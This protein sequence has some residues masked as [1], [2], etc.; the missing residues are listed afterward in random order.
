MCVSR[1]RLCHL[2]SF[3]VEVRHEHESKSMV[4]TYT[5][6]T[7]TRMHA[8]IL[9]IDRRDCK[10]FAIWDE[11][12]ASQRRFCVFCVSFS[13]CRQS[14]NLFSV[15]DSSALSRIS[16]C[17]SILP[18]NRLVCVCECLYGS[19]A[20]AF[21]IVCRYS[22][23]RLPHTLTTPRTLQHIHM[24]STC[25]EFGATICRTIYDIVQTYTCGICW[26]HCD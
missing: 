3:G 4:R 6:T 26:H 18:S 24:Q 21:C 17:L 23:R 16:P 14:S 5:H 2:I 19:R 15:F 20:L 22:L 11:C 13:V 8:A 12:I 1:A 9:G 10:I 7:R 25:F